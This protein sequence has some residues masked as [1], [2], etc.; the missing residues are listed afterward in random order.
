[1]TQPL[2]LDELT[3]YLARLRKMKATLAEWRGLP[4]FEEASAGIDELAAVA[5]EGMNQVLDYCLSDKE[6]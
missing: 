5:I 6:E 3:A 2:S 1:M 4:G